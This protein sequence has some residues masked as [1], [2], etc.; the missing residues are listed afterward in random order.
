MKS[1]LKSLEILEAVSQNQPVS[2]GVLARLLDMPKSSVQ[3]V[4]LT[5]HEAGWLRQT[6]GD[7]TR[8]EVGPRIL[9][10]RPAALRGGALYA[11]AREPMREL[12]DLTNE[13]VH[14]S[15]PD[16]TKSMVLIDRAD[17]TQTVRT[18]SP[19]GDLSPFHA[20][21]TGLAVLAHMKERDVEE[22]LSRDL[23][24][25][26]EATPCDPAE[27][28]LELERIRQRGYSVNLSQYRHAVCAI[29]APIIDSDGAP[30]AS[31]CISM[32]ESRYDPA[33]LEEWGNAVAK[34]AAA[35]SV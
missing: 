1:L 30:A 25:F 20:T 12:R 3:R 21:A 6:S 24:K 9:G 22:I 7:L 17:C 18:F 16:S 28:R 26:S 10:V 29:G 27:I 5:F 13:T 35:V 11:A 19:I 8:W 31:I 34:A 4:L 32:P 23:A 33:R 14:L 2:V 15:V